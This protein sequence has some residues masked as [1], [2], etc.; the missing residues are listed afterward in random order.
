MIYRPDPMWSNET[1]KRR[2]IGWELKFSIIPRRSYYTGKYLW[3]KKAWRGTA[4]L[5]GP[6]EPVAEYRWCSQEELLFL[7]L[8]GTI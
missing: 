1:F 5:T 3:L 2:C 6:G 8:K 4:L 7:K